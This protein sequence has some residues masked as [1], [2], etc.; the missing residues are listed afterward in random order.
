MLVLVLVIHTKDPRTLRPGLRIRGFGAGTALRPII[1]ALF[2]PS[3]RFSEVWLLF[4]NYTCLIVKCIIVDNR[5]SCHQ[6]VTAIIV[7][8]SP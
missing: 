6:L 7:A 5:F 4:N 8:F 3:G 2:L 1:R